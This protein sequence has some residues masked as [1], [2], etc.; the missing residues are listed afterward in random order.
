MST[1]QVSEQTNTAE[2]KNRQTNS[3]EEEKALQEKKTAHN[4]LITDIQDNLRYGQGSIAAT[5]DVDGMTLYGLIATG[6]SVARML[7]KALEDFRDTLDSD[8]NTEEEKGTHKDRFEDISER[9]NR[10]VQRTD[11]LSRRAEQVDLNRR[12]E[13]FRDSVAEITKEF[14]ELE[15]NQ[16]KAVIGEELEGS[17]RLLSNHLDKIGRT[18]GIE[19]EP[20]GRIDFDISF[21]ADQQLEQLE[22]I[23]Q[24]LE[25]RVDEL[26]EKLTELESSDFDLGINKPT[27]EPSAEQ[28]KPE[29]SK[30]SEPMSASASRSSKTATKLAEAFKAT[31]IVK[32]TLL[33]DPLYTS[34]GR[35][36]YRESDT[37]EEIIVTDEGNRGVIFKAEKE[38]GMSFWQT[39]GDDDKLTDEERKRISHA[40]STEEEVAAHNI[41]TTLQRSYPEAFQEGEEIRVGDDTQ[42]FYTFN[43][44]QQGENRSI[45]GKDFEQAGFLHVQERADGATLIFHFSDPVTHS[46][47]FDRAIAAEQQHRDKNAALSGV[48]PRAPAVSHEL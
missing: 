46:Q 40:P 20:S 6:S 41:I 7:G 3:R 45:F 42:G 44:V 39:K 5:E 35:I 37:K 23:L 22:V 18:A 32:G 36:D 31:T 24:E 34:V 16:Q 48:R 38:A 28:F 11:N 21:P 47:N 4:S 15:E 33:T 8:D 26:D 43:T 9:F 13:K 19:Q 10:L 14:S 2:V 12:E 29:Q 17:L 27:A 25:S 1:P 30:L